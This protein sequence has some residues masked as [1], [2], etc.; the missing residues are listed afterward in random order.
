MPGF[1][2]IEAQL[3]DSLPTEPIKQKLTRQ[4]RI[5]ACAHI[6]KMCEHSPKTFAQPGSMFFDV[7]IGNGAH[8][9]RGM[10]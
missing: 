9:S 7:L 10:D 5:I 1:G 2:I 8:V 3:N 4:I 6:Q